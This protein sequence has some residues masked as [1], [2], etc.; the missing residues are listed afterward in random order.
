MV[1]R[2]LLVF[3]RDRRRLFTRWI[4]CCR[5]SR[6]AIFMFVVGRTFFSAFR[7][8]CLDVALD[9]VINWHFWII[10]LHTTSYR[11]SLS[12]APQ[13]LYSCIVERLATINKW[14]YRVQALILANIS[15]PVAKFQFALHFCVS[16][17]YHQ[18][19]DLCSR[20]SSITF[21]HI[22]YIGFF[23]HHNWISQPV[24]L[25]EASIVTSYWVW[26]LMAQDTR[27][28]SGD[29]IRF[30]AAGFESILVALVA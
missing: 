17:Q 12:A 9:R 2:R 22:A 24:N 5:Y 27:G 7:S 18:R 10:Q 15:L 8:M 1:R 16:S 4:A 19:C 13:F 11:E 29:R 30:T 3:L 20:G 14:F 25:Q 21:T 26:N 23:L 6:L 28:I